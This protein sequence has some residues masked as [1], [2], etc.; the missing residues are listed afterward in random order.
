MQ[1][2]HKVEISPTERSIF[3]LPVDTSIL[4][5]NHKGVYKRHLEKRRTKLLGKLTFLGKFLDADEKIAFVTTGCS[6]CTLFEQLT[7]GALWV[8]LIKRALFVFTNKRVFHIPTTRTFNYRGSVAQILYQDCQR[9]RVKGSTFVAEYHNGRKE[10]FLCIPRR[11][12]AVIK[13][14]Q[15]ATSESDRRSENPQRNHLCPNCTKVLPSGAVTCP[16]CG[17]EFKSRHMTLIRYRYWKG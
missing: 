17:L 14:F 10:K 5:V 9:L 8:L 16:T 6:P 13:R 11:D 4:F 15:F 7:I 1:V 12:R 2:E 3:G